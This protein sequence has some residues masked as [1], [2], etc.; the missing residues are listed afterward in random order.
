MANAEVFLL[1][2]VSVGA[3]AIPFLTRQLQMPN[4][5]GEIIY[6][7]L[8]GYLLIDRV[9]I[10]HSISFLGELGFILLMYLAGLEIDFNRIRKTPKREILVYCVMY[11]AIGGLS[12]G[13]VRFFALPVIYGLIFLT[14]AVG[15]LFPVLKDSRLLNSASGQKFLLIGTIGEIMSLMAFTGFILYYRYG[16]SRDSLFHLFQ[17]LLFSVLIIFA[18]KVYRYVM[19]WNPKLSKLIMTSDNTFESAVRGNL[20]NMFLFVLIA[21]ILDLELIIG[22]FIGG[23]IFAA[24][25]AAKEDVLE[26]IGSFGYGFLVPMFFITVGMKFNLND[27]FNLS[28]LQNSLGIVGVILVVRLLACPILL[29]ADFSTREMLATAVSLTFPLTLLV[30][31]ATF[32]LDSGILQKDQTAAVLLA[33]ILTSVIY[34]IFFK[35]L[36]SKGKVSIQSSLGG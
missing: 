19:W 14:T 25:F 5:A 36:V 1:V 9:H 26:K 34:P 8:V 27:F 16:F 30:A 6:G 20:A 32:G 18:L 2:L 10:P 11:L 12:F 33:A 31:I 3:F 28:V 35:K 7:L 13:V 21:H 15:L 22:A 17:I 23:M 29:L 24:I 4:A